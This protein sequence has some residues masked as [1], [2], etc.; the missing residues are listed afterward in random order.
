MPKALGIKSRRS[1][2]EIGKV[3]M[4]LPVAAKIALQSAG[5]SGGRAN[6]VRVN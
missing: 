6:A 4:R 1:V 5:A 2:C 3:R